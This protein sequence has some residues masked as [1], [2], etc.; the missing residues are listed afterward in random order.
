MTL[1]NHW[2]QFVIFRQMV[3]QSL[4]AS[5]VL[6]HVVALG[7]ALLVASLY[8]VL[9]CLLPIVTHA[10]MHIHTHTHTRHINSHISHEPG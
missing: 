8:V 10:H 5:E 3:G 7:N 4:E 2:K 1:N 6:Q 9:H